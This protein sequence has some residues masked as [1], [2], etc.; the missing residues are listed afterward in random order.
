M[1]TYTADGD[2][3][4]GSV[5]I[6][7]PTTSVLIVREELENTRA[8]AEEVLVKLIGDDSS[9]GLLGD[10][11]D[12]LASAPSVNITPQEVDTTITLET[13]GQVVP[14]FDES[15]LQEFP[16]ETY[17]A[18]TMA[19]LPTV[20]TDFT[21]VTEPSDITLSLAW[22]EA[23]LPTELFTALKA[24]LLT[25]LTSGATGLDPAVEEAIYER[26]RT[27]QAADRLSEYNRINA[28]AD[29]MQFAYPSGVLLSA[30][31]GFGIG[32][33][34]MDADIENQIIV[35]QG[36]LAQKNSQFSIQQA[37]ALEQLLRQTRSEESQRA[38]DKVTKIAEL[39]IQD[40]SERVKK[41][42]GIWEGRKVKVQAQVEA[43]RGVI[44]SNK[45]LIDIFS[46]QYDALSTRVQAVTSY[47]KGLTDVF[48]GRAQG[49]SAAEQA[50]SSRNDSK[51]KLLAEQIKN[52]DLDLRGQ[53][54]E[55]EALVQSY[56]AEQSVRERIHTAIA[57]I[58]SQVS[59]SLLAAVST[60]LGAH[61]SASESAGKSYSVSVGVSESHSVEHNPAS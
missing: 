50:V 35:S 39:S 59:A 33:N 17:D 26:A 28:S 54:A 61:Y 12:G 18:P 22:A 47:N 23:T 32:A 60:S 20:D 25:D 24:R 15:T 30:L 4:S 10:M 53:I 56:S 3:I 46:K 1:P 8:R 55:A 16:N 36:E 27:R 40:F 19:S 41:F 58:A 7:D 37:T 42:M 48:T 2:Y 21:D 38:L 57:N 52:A 9:S 5:A 14:T 44:E 51:V 29:D 34:R 43:L 31:T 45:G 49:F 11:L 13:S 6:N